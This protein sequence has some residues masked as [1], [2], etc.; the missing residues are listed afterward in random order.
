MS[1]LRLKRPLNLICQCN[2]VMINEKDD[3]MLKLDKQKTFKKISFSFECEIKQRLIKRKIFNIRNRNSCL[4][5]CP[6]KIFNFYQSPIMVQDLCQENTL[7]FLKIQ[8]DI[9]NRLLLQWVFQDEPVLYY[10][11]DIK[12]SISKKKVKMNKGS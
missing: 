2:R 8:V 6:Q 12:H 9:M 5:W 7:C 1:C 3:K 4:K 10:S 11:Y